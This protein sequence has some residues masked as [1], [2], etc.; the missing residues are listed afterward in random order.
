[1]LVVN[2]RSAFV[3][4]TDLSGFVSKALSVTSAATSKSRAPYY[5]NT[6]SNATHV[7]WPSLTIRKSLRIMS[8]AT[9]TFDCRSVTNAPSTG[10]F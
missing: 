2:M 6:Q 4:A 1:V 10:A 5:A 9:H 3:A 8:L 7:F